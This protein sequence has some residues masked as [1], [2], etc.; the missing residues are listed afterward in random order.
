MSLQELSPAELARLTPQERTREDGRQALIKALRENHGLSDEEIEQ[1]LDAPPPTFSG[2]GNQYYDR[3]A[4]AFRP[5][6][7][8]VG[9]E[10]RADQIPWTSTHAPLMEERPDDPWKGVRGFPE[11]RW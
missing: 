2:P 10:P 5:P 11:R 4:N 3:R 1:R 6:A 8:V 9:Q 7:P